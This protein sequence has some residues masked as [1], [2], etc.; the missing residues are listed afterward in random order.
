MKNDPRNI[1][2]LVIGRSCVDVIGV[3]GR[4]LREDTKV[5]LLWRK[6]EGGGQ[7]GTAACCIS[8]LGGRT[9]YWG[10]VGNDDEGRLCLRRLNDFH[11]DGQHVEIVLEGKTPV[12]YVF[13]TQ[14]TGARTIFYDRNTLPPLAGAHLPSLLEP[15]P[16]VI[17]LDPEGAHLMGEI[18]KLGH[19]SLIVYDC[20]RWYPGM[21]EAM[22]TADY[23]IPSADFL[24]ESKL[25]LTHLPFSRQVRAL[26]QMVTGTL[27]IT[28]GEKGAFYLEEK[29]LLRVPA[30]PVT[31]LD[32]TGAGDNF[33]AAFS[34]ALSRQFSL[35]MTV[36]FSVAVASLSCRA[37]GGRE[38]IPTWEE[39]TDVA[40]SLTAE[41]W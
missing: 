37:Y 6:T 2:V 39:A 36:K 33:H 3:I 10:R 19:D 13:I 18:K 22:A 8:R 28:D 31:V 4:F 24:K 32:T 12:A 14:E 34:L 20:E 9:R 7:G 5:P 40:T 11:V 1:D 26:A 29:Q 38:G 41:P 30:P 35:S 27:V 17:L 15:P 25:D 16:R 23:F 21:R